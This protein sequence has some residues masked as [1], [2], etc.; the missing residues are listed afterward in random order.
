[1]RQNLRRTH[2]HVVGSTNGIFQA[3]IK[4]T[5]ITVSRDDDIGDN[6]FARVHLGRNRI[7]SA[8]R[9]RRAL[10]LIDNIHLDKM[11]CPHNGPYRERL[12]FPRPTLSQFSYA[13]PVVD[14]LDKVVRRENLGLG[15]SKVLIAFKVVKPETEHR[16]V[17]RIHNLERLRYRS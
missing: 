3:G 9:K 15:G 13:K 5:T 11:L 4:R 7:N 12:T 16:N 14:V 10:Q 2:V 1:M 6:R 8:I 17:K